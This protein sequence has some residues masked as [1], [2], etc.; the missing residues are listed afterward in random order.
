MSS[1]Y[2]LALFALFVSKYELAE[3]LSHALKEVVPLRVL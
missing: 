1:P 2:T 3:T